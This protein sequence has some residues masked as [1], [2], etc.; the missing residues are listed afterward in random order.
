MTRLAAPHPSPT[1]CIVC[2][3]AFEDGPLLAWHLCSA[4]CAEADR[5]E[6]FR[7]QPGEPDYE[8]ERRQRLRE[9]RLQAA[10]FTRHAARSA[11][12]L[13]A[14]EHWLELAEADLGHYGPAQ[15]AARIEVLVDLYHLRRARDPGV[16]RLGPEDVRAR[17]WAMVPTC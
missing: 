10:L 6:R 12:K 9:E 1:T 5:V 14:D 8:E 4:T 3:A 7:A 17:L 2:G 15:I 16:A 11:G 13:I